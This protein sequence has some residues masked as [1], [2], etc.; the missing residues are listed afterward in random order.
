MANCYA[1]RMGISDVQKFDCETGDNH[2]DMWVILL[3][4]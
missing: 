4:S 3:A 2:L 1:D